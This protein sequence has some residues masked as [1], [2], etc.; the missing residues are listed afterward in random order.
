[1]RGLLPGVLA[2]ATGLF[3][4]EVKQVIRVD[5]GTEFLTSDSQRVRLLGIEAPEIYQAGGD[6]CRDVLEKYVLGRKVRLESDGQDA[7]DKGRLL[8]C[9]FVGDTLVNAALVH[10]GFASVKLPE[11]GLK[12][13]DS[14]QKLEQTAARVGKGLWPFDVF[15]PPSFTVPEQYLADTSDVDPW[16][17]TV[18]W[19]ETDK[20]YGR[21]VRVVGTVVA[22]YKSDKVFIMNFH[23]DYRR[24]FKAVVF[25]GD[26]EKFPPYPE[27]FYKKRLVR[28]TGIIKEYQN[29]PEMIINDPGQ[30]EI[31][32]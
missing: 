1:M 6:I 25:A 31:L 7:D 8:R 15:A 17:E 19:D 12:Y 14:L 29:A 20:Y 24:H 28:V 27:D 21:L 2:I 11:E 18:S 23:Q 5:S 10:K 22:T 16:L 30:I 9:V 13:G 4:A 32:E 3:A 26:L